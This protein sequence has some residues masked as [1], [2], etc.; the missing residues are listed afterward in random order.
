MVDFMEND[1]D[2]IL[3]IKHQSLW[4]IYKAQQAVN[5]I[6]EEVPLETDKS[7]FSTLSSDVQH[8]ILMI[9]GFFS[10]S[11]QIVVDNLIENFIGEVKVLECRAFYALQGAIETVHS[12][13]YAALLRLLAPKNH[14]INDACRNSSSILMKSEWAKKFMDESISFEK[15]LWAFACF[16]GVLFQGSFCILFYLKTLGKCRGLTESNDFIARDEALHALFA[17][18]MLNMTK[19]KISVE[20]AVFIMQ[21]AIKCEAKFIHETFNKGGKKLAF[22][23]LTEET[24]MQYIHSCANGLLAMLTNLKDGDTIKREHLF[25]NAANPFGFMLATDL[26]AKSNFFEREVTEYA[27]PCGQ[28]IEDTSFGIDDDF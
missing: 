24:V 15:R 16:E 2:I 6:V 11:D 21:E 25:E 3:P 9:L 7:D 28:S 10:V 22:G 14:P 19:D 1:R 20:D 5:W 18:E 27:R 8:I 13:M 23:N 26:R 4:N 12:E 17:I